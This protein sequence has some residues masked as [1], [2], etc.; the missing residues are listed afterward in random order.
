MKRE[1]ARK[2]LH[3]LIALAPLLALW[4]RTGTLLLLAAGITAWIVFETLRR[5]GI[6][7]PVV[8]SITEYA[9]REREKGRFI[10]GPATLGLGA[11]GAL[12]LYPQRAAAVAVLA[13]AFG[14]GLASLAGK[15][16][17]RLRPAFLC[18]KSVEGSLACFAAVFV[19]AFLVS[20]GRPVTALAAAAAAAVAEA[21][22]LQDWDNVAVP[23]ASGGVLCLLSQCVH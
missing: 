8:S 14:D 15:W 4:S 5:R 6:K 1:L 22:P 19:C 18:G 9:S 12:L 2:S 3:L 20:G 16:C 7:V 13:L 23:L 21:L 11:A 10:L 17:G